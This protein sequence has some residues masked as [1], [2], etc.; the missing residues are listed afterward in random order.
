MKLP[1][2]GDTLYIPGSYHISRGSDDIDGGLATISEVQIL[3]DSS[4]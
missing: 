4:I 3:L 1:E 2:I